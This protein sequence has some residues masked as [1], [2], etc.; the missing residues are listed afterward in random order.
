MVGAAPTASHKLGSLPNGGAI[1]FV[2]MVDAPKTPNTVCEFLSTKTGPGFVFGNVPVG[3]RTNSG[4]V[5]P[6][7]KGDHATS[8]VRAANRI[9]SVVNS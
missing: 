1:E 3:G 5:V 9:S 2:V 4:A 8:L 6:D 7:V